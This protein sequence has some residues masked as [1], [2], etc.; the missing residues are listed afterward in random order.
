MQDS[1]YVS[2]VTPADLYF[3]FAVTVL[4]QNLPLKKVSQTP[5]GRA[6][7]AASRSALRLLREIP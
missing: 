3:T 1:E 4:Q 2:L 5:F 6:A 7:E